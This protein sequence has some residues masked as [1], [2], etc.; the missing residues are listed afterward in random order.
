MVE[1]RK[2]EYGLDTQTPNT[3]QELALGL[4]R[5]T[6]V[7]KKMDPLPEDQHSNPSTHMVTYNY[8]SHEFQRIQCPLLFAIGTRYSCGKMHIYV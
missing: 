5:Y 4:E 8:L 3:A 6:S 1:E 7:I 2:T